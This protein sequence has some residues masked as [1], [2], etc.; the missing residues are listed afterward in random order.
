MLCV[1]LTVFELGATYRTVKAIE[2][3][4][5]KYSVAEYNWL[6]T[7]NVYE[8]YNRYYQTYG[9]MAAYIF[10][11]Q[12]NLS[13]QV[14]NQETGETWADYVKDYTDRTFVE[15]TKLYDDAKANGYELDAEHLETIESDSH[16]DFGS[17]AQ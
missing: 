14:Y 2:V 4:G 3:D 6:Y 5:T 17:D 11:P 10:N 7:N 13:E 9:E 16:E 12:G 8:I 1:V 15:M